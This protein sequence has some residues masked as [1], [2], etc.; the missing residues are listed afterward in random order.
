MTPGHSDCVIEVGAQR[1]S[2]RPEDRD[3]PATWTKH[4]GHLLETSL[5]LC[6][7]LECVGRDHDVEDGVTKRQADPISNAE[8]DARSRPAVCES[9][10]G[11]NVG[12]GSIQSQ[13]I[14]GARLRKTDGLPSEPTPHVEHPPYGEGHPRMMH[15]PELIFGLGVLPCRVGLRRGTVRKSRSRGYSIQPQEDACAELHVPTLASHPPGAHLGCAWW[16]RGLS[17]PREPHPRP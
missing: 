16:H 3:Q 11:A 6:Q 5:G 10:G 4:S 9:R 14:T 13:H 15:E 12:V 1:R 2:E 7:V 8:L 17:C